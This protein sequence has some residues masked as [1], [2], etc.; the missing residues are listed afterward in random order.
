MFY[1]SGARGG[2]RNAFGQYFTREPQGL[3][4][5]RIDSAVK[6]QWI[7]PATGEL[8]GS[9]PLESVYAIRI[10]KGTTIY[11]GPAG[12][13]SGIYLGGGDQIYI[14]RPWELDGAQVV[15][16]TPIG[17]VTPS[18]T[19]LLVVAEPTPGGEVMDTATSNTSATTPGRGSSVPPSD[20]TPTSRTDVELALDQDP[21]PRAGET[22]EQATQRANLAIGE[23]EARDAFQTYTLLGDKPPKVNIRANDDVPANK[24]AGAH[25]MDRHGPDVPLR[26]V[27][28]SAGTRTIEGRIYGDPPWSKPEN[29]SYKWI[30]EST[31]NGTIN[32]YLSA[33]WE[34]IRSD[35]TLNEGVF[36]TTF[37]ADHAVGEGFFNEGQMGVGARNAVYHRTSYVTLTIE[38]RPGNP[39]TFFIVR[40][41]PAGRG[42]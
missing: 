7:D 14:A 4:Q 20:Y 33:N 32:D 31:M 38:L 8:T 29:W 24:V 30:D 21:T 36:E 13:Q 15:S 12:F 37:N 11:E 35:L 25:S 9:S 27:D 5:T 16:E 17:E 3:I 28:A 2:G 41:F 23:I 40:A 34:R 39:P 22:P 18:A 19:P 42:Y 26:I 1:R 10:P 6:A